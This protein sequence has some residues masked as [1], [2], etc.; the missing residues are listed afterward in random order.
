MRRRPALERITLTHAMRLLEVNNHRLDQ[1]LAISGIIPEI[2]S[3]DRRRKLISMAQLEQLRLAHVAKLR[4]SISG[5]DLHNMEGNSIISAILLRLETLERHV[6]TYMAQPAR[7]ERRAAPTDSA[8]PPRPAPRPAHQVGQI[9][10]GKRNAATLAIKHGANSWKSA[11]DW[12]WQESDLTDDRTALRF[13]KGY[14]DG[15]PRAGA[16]QACTLP[17]CTCSQV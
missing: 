16:W 8:L 17:D 5:A 13:I 7:T 15:H 1:L 6:A 12:Y 9:G 10:I 14:L 3:N 2:A 11:M 4:P